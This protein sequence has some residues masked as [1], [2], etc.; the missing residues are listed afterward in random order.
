MYNYFYTT[1]EALNFLS[2]KGFILVT[3]YI[4]IL[5]GFTSKEGGFNTGYVP[6]TT[7]SSKP[8][9]CFKK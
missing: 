2:K 9:F 3:I 5:S 8:V 7:V 1:T 4:D 6:I